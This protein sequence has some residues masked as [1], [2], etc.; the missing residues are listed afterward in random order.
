[1][2]VSAIGEDETDWDYI[3]RLEDGYSEDFTFYSPYPNPSKG[4]SVT[5]QF[6]VIT[7]Q[8]IEFRII[9]LLG[10]EVWHFSKHY[11]EPEVVTLKWPGLNKSGQRVANGIYFGIMEGNTKTK[12]QKITYLKKSD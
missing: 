10:Q 4:Q 2:I 3:L 6:Q 12:V 8:T 11:E 9:D 7:E 5:L 1:L